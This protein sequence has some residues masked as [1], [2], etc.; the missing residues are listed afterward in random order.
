[1]SVITAEL[2]AMTAVWAAI[3][4]LSVDERERVMM[5]IGHRISQAQRNAAASLYAQRDDG[6]LGMQSTANHYNTLSPPLG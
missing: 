5:W 1:M 3:E 4:G 6:R 2:E